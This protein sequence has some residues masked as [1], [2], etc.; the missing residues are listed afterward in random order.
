MQRLYTVQNQTIAGV[1]IVAVC[2]ILSCTQKK[3]VTPKNL[4]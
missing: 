2:L 3:S 1:L 4:Q